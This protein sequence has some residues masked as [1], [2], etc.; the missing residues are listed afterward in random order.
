M[1]E[2]IKIDPTEVLEKRLAT[3]MGLDKYSKIMEMVHS[4]DVSTNKEFQR[5]FNGFYIVRRNEEWREK[6]YNLFEQKK[7]KD[8]TFEGILKEL[9][10]LT[11]NVEASFSSKMY[12]TI[13]PDKPI[14]DRY[15]VQ[16]LGIKVPEVDKEEKIG[17]II[18]YY[19]EIEK[20][21]ESFLQTEDAKKCV[22]KFDELLPSYRWFS[23]VKKIDFFLW[24]IR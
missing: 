12:A 24:S 20:W 22:K 8:V 18:S 1:N 19:K 23:D 15:V 6:Y 9:F 7:M 14:W 4:V 5:T 13:Y 21:Y 16:N 3:G 17:I 2:M 11:G 10:D